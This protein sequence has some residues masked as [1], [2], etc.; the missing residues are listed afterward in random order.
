MIVWLNGP[1]GAGKTTLSEKLRE[2]LPD[3]LIFDPEEIG[4]VVRAIV[5]PAPSGDF[6]DLPIWR[7]LTLAALLALRGLYTRPV[8]VPMTLVQPA[9]MEEI[10]AG[11]ANQGERLLHVFLDI[12][13][14]LLRSRIEA[15]VM[16]MDPARDQEIRQWRLA[17]VDRCLTAR[18]H[19]P[20]GTRFLD[21]GT[22]GPEA[23]A[24]QVLTWM[25]G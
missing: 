19:M 12:D 22:D 11:L 9:Y 6:Q 3:S 15:Q 23:L 17:Q 5:P 13:A 2:R 10:F 18:Q 24:A 25:R 20:A 21:S 1:F 7:R 8:I 16:A 4:F 14:Q